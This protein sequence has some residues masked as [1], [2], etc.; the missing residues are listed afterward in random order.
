MP[1]F[2]L[3]YSYI[4]NSSSRIV[5]AI[6][7]YRFHAQ[8]GS[9]FLAFMLIL[10]HF[11]PVP[12]AK[13]HLNVIR[14]YAMVNEGMMWFEGE[15]GTIVQYRMFSLLGPARLARPKHP[16]WLGER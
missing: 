15:C 9:V 6:F 7:S 3:R 13:D 12:Y 4:L 11:E 10:D 1:C 5:Q 16:F 8:I 14:G 2:H